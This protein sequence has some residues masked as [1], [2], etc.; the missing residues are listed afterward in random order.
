MV[1]V[2]AA[3][4]MFVLT[5]CP[6]QRDGLP[7]QLASA[8][9]ETQAAA[10]SAALSLQLWLDGRSTRQLT[11]VQL[12]DARDEIVKAFKGVATLQADDPADAH[13]QAQVTA[14]MSAVIEDLNAANLAVR[15]ARGDPDPRTLRRD[16]LDRVDA[17]EREYR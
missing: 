14:A 3:A 9:D 15:A 6:S 4:V 13:R 2:L 10:R 8:K 1:A 12:A 16:L 5:S 11:S 17:L 7:G